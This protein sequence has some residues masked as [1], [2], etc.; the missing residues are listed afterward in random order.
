MSPMKHFYRL[1]FILFISLFIYSCDSD[2]E[3]VFLKENY[4]GVV[5]ITDDGIKEKLSKK[6]S[7]KKRSKTFEKQYKSH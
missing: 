1:A 5:D 7:N 4:E 6:N 2:D 3:K